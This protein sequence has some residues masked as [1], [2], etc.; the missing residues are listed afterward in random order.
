MPG[1]DEERSIEAKQL[2]D[3]AKIL[4]KK[5]KELDKDLQ[6]K[7]EMKDLFSDSEDNIYI[8]E[9]LADAVS[10]IKL[11]HISK[12]RRFSKGENFSRFCERFIEYVY[13]TKMCDPK[14]YMF[15]LQNVD[16]ETYTNLKLVSLSEAE[17]ADA[18]L[19]CKVYKDAIYG[20]ESLSLKNAVFDCKQNRGETISDYVYRLRETANIAYSTDPEKGDENCLLAFLRGVRDTHMKMKINEATLDSFNEIVKLAKKIE[21]VDGMLNSKP[22]TS[23]SSRDKSRAGSNRCYSSNTTSVE[24]REFVRAQRQPVSPRYRE[25]RYYQS[26]NPHRYKTCWNCFKVGHVRRFCDNTSVYH[27]S[28]YHNNKQQ[29]SDRVRNSNLENNHDTDRSRS[30]N[31]STSRNNSMEYF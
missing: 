15:F 5:S 21:R 20:D 31:N 28:H 4:L 16:D 3:Q 1:S 18:H 24:H 7:Q 6:L 11:S 17:K 12:L 14:L 9:E 8:T 22:R 25:R 30:I 26:R 2:I 13:I 27:G 23:S 19:F 29:N 10:T